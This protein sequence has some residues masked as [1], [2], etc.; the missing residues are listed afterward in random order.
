MDVGSVGGPTEWGSADGFRFSMAHVMW[1][2]KSH[3]H[4]RRK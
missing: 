3:F 4:L 1:S 2:S